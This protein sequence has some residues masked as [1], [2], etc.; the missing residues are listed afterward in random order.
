MQVVP[1]W[2]KIRGLL[3]LFWDSHIKQCGVKLTPTVDQI[4]GFFREYSDDLEE[5]ERLREELAE[6]EARITSAAISGLGAIR[7]PIRAVDTLEKRLIYRERLRAKILQLERATD[8]ER[9][10]QAIRLLE[11]CECYQAAEMAR[12]LRLIYLDQR[13]L[14]EAVRSICGVVRGDEK[15]ETVQRRAI[16]MRERAFKILAEVCPDDLMKGG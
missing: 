11:G 3:V 12:L 6:C 9:R 2:D 10:E 8:R 1:F 4:R 14:V 13:P 15:Y 16:R 7:S 5:L